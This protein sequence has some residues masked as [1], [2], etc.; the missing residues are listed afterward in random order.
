MSG[1][2]LKRLNEELKGRALTKE[3]WANVDKHVATQKEGYV[4]GEMA[5]EYPLLA[6]KYMPSKAAYEIF[7]CI[8]CKRLNE[9]EKFINNLY[10]AHVEKRECGDGSGL[11]M[12]ISR[13]RMEIA[14]LSAMEDFMLSN[15][16]NG[17]RH[18]GDFIN[19]LLEV[20]P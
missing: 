9:S 5:R 4:K 15:Q 10:E 11:C 20:L 13:G 17:N 2:E 12:T 14:N 7:L 3:E 6:M 19:N 16:M 8:S 1:A 18:I